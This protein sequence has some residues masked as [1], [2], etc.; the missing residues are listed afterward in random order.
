MS[1]AADIKLFIS[2]KK[3]W[4]LVLAM[5]LYGI[6]V[7]ILAPMNSIYLK[8][9]IGLGKGEIA[10][11]FAISLVLNMIFTISV[12]ILSD[13]IPRKK[14]IPMAA[15]VVCAAGLLIYM[16]A[17]GYVSALVGMSIASAP[18]GMIMGQ[19]FAM[20]R[21]HFSK[22]A[23]DIVEIS[24]LWL[25][26]S[27]SVGFFTGLLLGANIYLWFTFYGVLWG[28]LGGYTALFV[29]LLFYRET[30][31]APS[32]AVVKKSGEPFS[33][34]MLAALLMLSCA[35]AIRGLY[36]PLVV[37][38]KFGNPE[39]M[40]YIWSAQ[41][42]FELLFMTVAGYWAL[43]YGFKPVI[44]FAG[45]FALIVYLVYANVDYLPFFFAMQPLYS[46]YVAVL[47]GVA[48]GYVQR[49]FLHKTGFGASLY[50]VISQMASL[51]GYFL[52]LLIDGITPSIF[53]IPA[54]LIVVS[55][56]LITRTMVKERGSRKPGNVQTL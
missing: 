29:L 5:I 16:R 13:K 41:A 10:S 54:A 12:G 17:G 46:F 9:G 8:E 25:R 15:A 47:L 18:S 43:K 26:A 19:M 55:M 45:L 52:P 11:I 31:E 39:L 23:P 3:A 20:A 42:V 27:F 1:V 24:Q 4:V 44:L 14:I 32:K 7:G 35:D 53:Y 2:V 34:A 50:V 49:M 28:N 38:E 48:M 56:L 36:L 30:V 21:N 6:G 51:V 40:S 33:L 37:N 22:L